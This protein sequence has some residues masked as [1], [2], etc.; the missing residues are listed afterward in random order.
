MMEFIVTRRGHGGMER[1]HE[2][3]HWC[4]RNFG[5]ATYDKTGWVVDFY[6]HTDN[7]AV[8]KI[9]NPTWAFWFQGRFPDTLT[10]DDVTQAIKDDPYT[11]SEY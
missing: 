9:Y 3:S 5:R 4:E 1:L 7:W 6:D 10:P 2:I 11:Y 8:F